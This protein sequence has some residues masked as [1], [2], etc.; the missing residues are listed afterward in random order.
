MKPEINGYNT[1]I[2]WYDAVMT[3]RDGDM[4]RINGINQYWPVHYYEKQYADP[5]LIE[6]YERRAGII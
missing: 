5:E 6:Y 4:I 3:E 1:N 2:P